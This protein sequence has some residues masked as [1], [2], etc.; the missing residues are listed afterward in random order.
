MVPGQD[1]LAARSCGGGRLFL[2]QHL[3]G[4]AVVDGWF[5]WEGGRRKRGGRR[6]CERVDLRVSTPLVSERSRE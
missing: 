2:R 5:G 1:R 3:Q 6:V 4:Q